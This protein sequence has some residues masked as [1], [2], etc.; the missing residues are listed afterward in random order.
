[1]NE[2]GNNPWIVPYSGAR[3]VIRHNQIINSQLE[4]YKVRPGAYGSQSAE[5]YDNTFSAEA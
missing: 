1:M 3:V 5:I 4:I 2:T